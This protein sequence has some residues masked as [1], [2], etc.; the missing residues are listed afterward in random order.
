MKYI[1]LRDDDTS[2]FTRF[3]DLEDA[4]S[5]ILGKYPITLAT[6]PFFHASGNK[7]L[8]FDADNDKFQKLRKWEKYASVEELNAYYDIT[9]IG[10]N[11]DLINRL[12]QLI[13]NGKI[14]IA[15]HGY[16][17]KYNER[18]AEMYSDAVSYYDLR[19]AKEYLEKCFGITVTTF[20]P[21]SNTIDLECFYNVNRLNMNLFTSGTPKGR[22]SFEKMVSCLRDPSP[23]IERVNTKRRKKPFKT[24][25]GIPLITSFT[26]GLHSDVEKLRDRLMEYLETYGFAAVGS[27]YWFLNNHPAERD[28]YIKM[29]NEIAEMNDV[30]FLAAN[31]YFHKM[32]ALY[33]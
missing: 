2:Y 11:P 33:E 9:P 27:H 29:L 31:D 20:I 7:I 6:V 22:T 16:C 4:Y 24:R 5:T 12:K 8:E 23:L 32:E 19:E 17:H 30:Q 26:F 28:A 21:P 13:S 10:K 1:C 14:E 15:L 18:G 25:C 3:E